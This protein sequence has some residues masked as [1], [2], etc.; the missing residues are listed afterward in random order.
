MYE[1]CNITLM[2]C[3]VTDKVKNSG[4][5]A[6]YLIYPVLSSSLSV[7]GKSPMGELEIKAEMSMPSRNFNPLSNGGFREK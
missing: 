7:R 6:I 3:L 1:Q 5:T 4:N 2:I